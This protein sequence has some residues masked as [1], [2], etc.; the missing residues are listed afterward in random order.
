MYLEMLKK[1]LTD[2]FN[3]DRT[4]FKPLDSSNTSWK[5][6]ILHRLN[7]RLQQK[8]Y[9]ICK[10]QTID[11]EHRINGRDWPANADTMIGLKRLNNIQYCVE[12]VI[13]NGIEGDLIETGVWRGGGAIFMKALLNLYIVKNKQ[14]WV[15]DSFE[16]LPKPDAKYKADV[17]DVHFK[18]DELKISLQ[19]VKNNFEKYGLLDNDVQFLK[20]WFKDTL[21]TA[22][23]ETLSVL[24][25]DGDMY[26][27]T[28]D[29]LVN[30]YPKLSC[31]GYIIVDDYGAVKGSK[32][33][34]TDY[35]KNHAITEE[36]REIDWSGVFWKKETNRHSCK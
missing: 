18:S 7:I 9:A 36:I 16:G 13:N 12:E 1:V 4:E 19:I 35:R 21:P 2:Y 15:A 30:L 26:E 5:R 14:V 22:P 20:G 32:L 24:R 8:G 28:M 25:L 6:K 10:T 3:I 23:I 11:K 34:V 33:A 31:G 27:S 29:A 17:G